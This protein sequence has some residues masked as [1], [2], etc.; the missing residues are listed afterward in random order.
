[1]KQSTHGARAL[2]MGPSTFELEED[3][4][5]PVYRWKCVSGRK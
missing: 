1:M 2:R 3:R 4:I 5:I